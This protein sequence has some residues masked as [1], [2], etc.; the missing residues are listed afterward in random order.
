M[1]ILVT[2]ATGLLGK[3][4]C[5]LLDREGWQYWACNSKIF[6]ITNT[7]MVN[8]IMNKI[9]LDF[10]IHLAGFTNIDQAEDNPKKAFDVNA[11]GTKNI[12]SIAKKH[13]I[14]ILYVSTDNVFDGKSNTP[15]KPSDATNPINVYGKSKLEGYSAYR[16][17]KVTVDNLELIP[18]VTDLALESG[19]NEVAGFEYQVR[20]SIEGIENGWKESPYMPHKETIR[21]MRQ[22]DELRKNWGV[23]YPW[24]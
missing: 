21:I 22:M 4:L 8:E 11:L 6:D 13:N 3:S 5:P 20:A 12:A 14:P 23:K 7:K 2:G 19:I 15:Y 17:V 10:I 18:K 16:V 1:R 9:S 24:D